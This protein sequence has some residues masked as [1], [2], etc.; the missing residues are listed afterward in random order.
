LKSESSYDRIY[1]VVKKIPF[2]KVA[3]YGQVACLAGLK[4][5]S[6]LVGYALHRLLPGADI[7]WQRVINAKGMLSFPKNNAFCRLQKQL[8][9]QE[10]IQ[11]TREM[12]DLKKYSWKAKAIKCKS[13]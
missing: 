7:P 4:G 13:F 2:G 11:F 10:G 9:A 1:R 3:T 12:I 5:Q 6:R 8:L